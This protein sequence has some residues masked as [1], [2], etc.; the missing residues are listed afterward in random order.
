[1]T[2]FLIGLGVG[3]VVTAP[4]AMWAALRWGKRMRLLERRTRIAERQ[5]ELGGMTSGLAHE[6]KNPLSTLGL[7]LQLLR[8]D[9]QQLVK[10]LP[11]K[12]DDDV[13]AVYRRFASL[14]RETYRLK[15]ILEDFLRF[16]GRMELERQPTP[17]HRVIE[18]LTDFYAPQAEAA[19][20]RLR[21]QFDSNIG[22][23]S[24]DEGLFKQALLN[25]MINATQA[26]ENA[27]KKKQPHGGADELIIR[28]ELAQ[29]LGSDEVCVHIT[30]TGPGIPEADQPRVFEPYFSKRR[31]GTGLGLPTARRIIEHHGGTLNFHTEPGRG[32]DFTITLPLEPPP[33]KADNPPGG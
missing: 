21:T 29:T 9:I 33:L 31:G 26:M 2:E 25:L 4:L 7:N 23:L 12:A 28:T 22:E 14:E 24:M 27:R 13:A 32:T 1:M 30:D 6:I 17:L 10:L 19:G 8:E 18:D 20:I 11:G 15:E 5:A 3:V 16:A